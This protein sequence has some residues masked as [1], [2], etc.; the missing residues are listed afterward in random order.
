MLL[1]SGIAKSMPFDVFC[2]VRVSLSSHRNCA[3]L[4]KKSRGW[5]QVRSFRRLAPTRQAGRESAAL[6]AAVA[7]LEPEGSQTADSDT[8]EDDSEDSDNS[9][10]GKD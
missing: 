3:L 9:Y 1:N 6:E 5:R 10:D 7:A 8:S 4:A 2:P